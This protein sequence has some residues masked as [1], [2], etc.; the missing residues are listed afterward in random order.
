MGITNACSATVVSHDM[1]R[2]C[3]MYS[4]HATM[5]GYMPCHSP[6]KCHASTWLHT[7]YPPCTPRYDQTLRYN[8]GTHDTL[9]NRHTC[10]AMMLVYMPRCTHT[11]PLT[12]HAAHMPCC[13]YTTLL[14]HHAAHMPCY[15]AGIHAAL[16]THHAAHMPCYDGGIHAALLTHHAAHMPCYDNGIHAALLTH[17]AS[18]MLC[19][20]AGIHAA[21]LTHHAAH[22]PCYDNGTHAALLTH[23]AAHMPCYDADI[24][25]CPKLSSILRQFGRA[26]GIYG[27]D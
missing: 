5:L 8:T 9:L 2:C 11:M 19:Y 25:T 12:C 1:L 7:C 23:H 14:T 20:D 24:H 26:G 21:L 4:H 3:H 13:S 6:C 15:D 27:W 17:H 10:H 22:M 18:H 16:L